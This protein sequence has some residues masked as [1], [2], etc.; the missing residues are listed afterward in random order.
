MQIV[1]QYM[2]DIFSNLF[3]WLFGNRFDSYLNSLYSDDDDE[4]RGV[5]ERRNNTTYDYN[6]NLFNCR[7]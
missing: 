6:N 3:D 7:K 4:E 5:Y 1:R 2:N